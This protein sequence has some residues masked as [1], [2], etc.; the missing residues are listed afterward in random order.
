MLI[1]NNLYNQIEPTAWIVIEG[2]PEYKFYY[3]IRDVSVRSFWY[4]SD[5]TKRNSW[6]MLCSHCPINDSS[7]YLLRVK[8]F[9]YQVMMDWKN[10]M[11]S[12]LL[13]IGP[14]ASQRKEQSSRNFSFP[15]KYF[16][17]RILDYHW[18]KKFSAMTKKNKL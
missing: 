10:F 16:E 14:K 15:G 8:R 2:V 6:V 4:H 7:G 17:Q 1:Q 13:D 18:P 3:N 12:T 11:T 5:D 9:I